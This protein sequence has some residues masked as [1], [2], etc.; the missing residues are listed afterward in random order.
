MA[1]PGSRHDL[2]ESLGRGRL[3]LTHDVMLATQ[4]F[5]SQH[6]IGN[7]EL[8]AYLFL[9]VAAQSGQPIRPTDLRDS[10]HLSG[11]AVTYVIERLVGR[12]IARRVPD[13]GDRRTYT[14]EITREGRDAVAESN[15][16]SD[17]RIHDALKHLP[18]EDIHASQRVMQA[19]T[20]ATRAFRADLEAS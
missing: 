3:T 11:A 6:G 13:P 1:S 18:D 16:A 20:T 15:N 17:R 4:V 14:V 12:G 19:L 10:L 9:V 5:G 8:A 2:E 7:S